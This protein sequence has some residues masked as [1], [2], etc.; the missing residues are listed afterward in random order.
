M[1]KMYFAPEADLTMLETA[2]VITAS[3]LGSGNAGDGAWYDLSNFFEHI[4]TFPNQ[5]SGAGTNYDE[6][7]F[8]G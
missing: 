3:V 4:E 7:D 2:D 6:S 1:K 5:S 8:L